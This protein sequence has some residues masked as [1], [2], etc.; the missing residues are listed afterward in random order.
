MTHNLPSKLIHIGRIQSTEGPLYLFLR[1]SASEHFIWFKETSSGNAEEEET[2]IFGTTINQALSAAR[3]YWRHASFRTVNCGFR[4]SLPERDEH[5]CN[6]LFHQMA[7]SY[8]SSNGVYFDED[9]GHNCII[10]F[11]SQEAWTLWQDL[12]KTGRLAMK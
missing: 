3:Q 12:K 4:Y 2:E 8:S 7:A 11:A 6:A 5:G 9:L 1:Q 10:H